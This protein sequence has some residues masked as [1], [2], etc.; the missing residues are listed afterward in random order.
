[1]G[2]ENMKGLGVR[3]APRV[4]KVARKPK[5]FPVDIELSIIPKRGL[6]SP[7]DLKF[8]VH[9]ERTALAYLKTVL[10]PELVAARK[11]DT[12]PS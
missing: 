9:I 10:I 1:M 3:S 8:A 5:G 12:T 7:E 4:E 6:N 11:C 2:I